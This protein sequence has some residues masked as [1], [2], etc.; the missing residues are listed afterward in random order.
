MIEVDG[1]LLDAHEFAFVSSMS[2]FSKFCLVEL[3]SLE[4]EN[5]ASLSTEDSKLYFI[6]LCHGS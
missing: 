1:L 6:F 3:V 2:I 4:T 5:G